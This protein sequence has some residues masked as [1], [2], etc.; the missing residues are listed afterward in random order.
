MERAARYKA[1]AIGAAVALTSLLLPL[2][3]K[4]VTVLN[5]SFETGT[6]SYVP[7]G[8]DWT[9]SYPSG[10][11][12]GVFFS[13]SPP[14]GTQAGFI[15]TGSNVAGTISQDL[16]GFTLGASYA[17]TFY[18]AGRPGYPADPVT[19]SLG[20]TDL[21]TFTPAFT[22]FAKVTSSL[23]VATSTDMTLLFAGSSVGGDIG[24][25]IDLVSVDSPAV[26]EPASGLV[27]LAG[28]VMLGSVRRFRGPTAARPSVTAS[29]A[30]IA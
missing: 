7:T 26:P 9:F 18:I 11:D 8:A 6:P 4:A 17:V 22:T 2:H 24:S 10:I 15:Q 3:A 23:L 29:G 30:S 20:G 5:P 16:T 21:G 28:A 27:L 14:D 12:T 13:G 25:A 1:S 19:V